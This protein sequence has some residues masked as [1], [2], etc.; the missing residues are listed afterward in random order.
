MSG[1]RD[2]F[3]NQHLRVKRCRHGVMMYLAND[4]YIGRSLDIYGEFCEAEMR[5]LG[6][7]AKSA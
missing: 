1:R 3:E 2:I 6:Q 7:I 5:L 4:I